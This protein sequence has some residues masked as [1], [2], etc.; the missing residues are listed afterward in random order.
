ML[1]P[2]LC[3]LT[4]TIPDDLSIEKLEETLNSLK[5]NFKEK[6]ELV[7]DIQVSCGAKTLYP[8]PDLQK[9]G[10]TAQVIVQ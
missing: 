4:Y 10:S 6:E 9:R 5:V 1:W 2:V 3:T 8:T 7:K